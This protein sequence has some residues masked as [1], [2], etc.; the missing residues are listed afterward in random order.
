MAT[1]LANPDDRYLLARLYNGDGDW[2]KAREQYRAIAAQIGLKRDAETLNRHVD[3][4]VQYATE[5]LK[6]LQADQDQE[7]LIEAQELVE[8][9]RLLR[10][11]SL[12]L[13]ILEA[14]IHRARN[15]I[16]KAVELI[17]TGADRPKLPPGDLL[18]LAALAEEFGQ[19]DLAERL[20]KKLAAQQDRLENR[21][22]LVRFLARTG[23]V[24]GRPRPVRAALEGD[25]QPGG[26]RPHPARCDPE[27]QEQG[28]VGAARA[29]RRVAAEGPRAAAQVVH[30]HARPGKPPRAPGTI[31]GSGGPVSP[32]YR[33]GRA[34]TRWSRSITSPG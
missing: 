23:R 31:P 25:D 22:P 21:L 12:D 33:S 1:G 4:V 16:S 19:T 8:K 13:L 14:R 30:P 27:R 34:A 2:P 32:G 20:L 3:Y 18:K 17:E 7:D 9:V 29:G 24:R 5:L 28:R 26:S 6:H 15:E 10:P 11:D